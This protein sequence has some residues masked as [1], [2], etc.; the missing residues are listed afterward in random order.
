MPGDLMFPLMLVATAGVVGG[1]A[2]SLPAERRIPLLREV[3]LL[4]ALF[5][6]YFGLRGI[7]EGNEAEALV[8]GRRLEDLERSLHLFIEPDLQ[9]SILDT[10]WIVDLANFIYIWAHWPVLGAVAIWLYREHRTRYPAY[11]NAI[12]ISGAIGIL[13]FLFY[14]AAPPRFA[15]P[16][17]VGTVGERAGY[18]RDFQPGF[19]SNQFAAI[20]SLHVGWSVLMGIALIRESNHRGAHILGVLLPLTMTWAV[21]VTGNHF[22]VDGVVGTILSVGGLVIAERWRDRRT[23]R[24]KTLRAPA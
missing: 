15:S 21:V 22:L 14:P 19:L 4:V 13:F 10:S 8:N 5:F 24:P 9:Q 18:Y 16:D 1:V 3:A 23:A 12:V 20:P 7:I 2:W 17:I 11:R 6:V